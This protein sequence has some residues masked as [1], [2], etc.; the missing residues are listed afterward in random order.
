[1]P[2]EVAHQRKEEKEKIK[3]KKTSDFKHFNI[4]IVL[5]IKN[6]HAL[7]TLNEMIDKDLFPNSMAKP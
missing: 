1:V 6:L 7:I 2:I 5:V 3:R 4:K